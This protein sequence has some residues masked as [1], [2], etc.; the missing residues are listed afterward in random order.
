[1]HLKE[2]IAYRALHCGMARAG[3]LLDSYA[4]I[5]DHDMNDVTDVR[6]GLSHF[7]MCKDVTHSFDT[8][9]LPT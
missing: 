8:Q 7:C 1:M 2:Q 6:R 3:P 4:S 9:V 5:S